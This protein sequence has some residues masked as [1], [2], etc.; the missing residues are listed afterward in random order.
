MRLTHASFF[1]RSVWFPLGSRGRIGSVILVSSPASARQGG[2]DQARNNEGLPI[3]NPEWYHFEV[4]WFEDLAVGNVHGITQDRYHDTRTHFTFAEFL[5]EYLAP[6]LPDWRALY[7]I[8]VRGQFGQPMR[9]LLLRMRV[10]AWSEM[11]CGLS[12]HAYEALD[13]YVRHVSLS[14]ADPREDAW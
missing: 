3:V 12:S 14:Y 13:L 9:Q 10:S 2:I 1:T 4:W 5:D 8:Q 7:N 11:F 6:T